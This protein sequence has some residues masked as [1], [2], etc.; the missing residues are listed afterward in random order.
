MTLF[1]LSVVSPARL[2]GRALVFGAVGLTLLPVAAH[3]GAGIDAL[4]QFLQ[5][6]RSLQAGFAQTVS[7]KSGRRSQQSAGVMQF[8]RPGKFR[9]QID[10]P[11]QQLMVGDGQSFWIYDPD[12]RQVTVKKLGAA[13]GST[14]AALLAGKN[15]LQQNF[16]LSE[17]G[18]EN[19][20]VWVEAIPKSGESGFE[21]IRLGFAGRELKA[22]QLFDTFGQTT[23]LTFSQIQRNLALP[24]SQFHFKPPA[25]TEVVRDMVRDKE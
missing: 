4:H 3:A 10:K 14:P 13:L 20:M 21:R 5:E 23:S 16:T 8:S 25:G 12:L 9:W 1:S 24:A 7:G 2:L 11:Y 15:E 6:T 19:G 22:M 18:E 17:A